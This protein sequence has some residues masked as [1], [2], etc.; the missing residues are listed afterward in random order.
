MSQHAYSASDVEYM[1]EV[2]QLTLDAPNEPEV[3]GRL[4]PHVVESTPPEGAPALVG[5]RTHPGASVVRPEL[6]V[7][8][9]AVRRAFLRCRPNGSA[10]VKYHD[11]RHVFLL[12]KP[13]ELTD[14]A[15]VNEW[16]HIRAS[17]WIKTY[18]ADGDGEV[19]WPDFEATIKERVA[20]KRLQ[21]K[22]IIFMTFDEPGSGPL[23]AKISIFVLLLIF[24]S[25]LAFVAETSPQ[26][27]IGGECNRCVE[28]EPDKSGKTYPMECSTNEE[29][30]EEYDSGWICGCKEP[31]PPQFFGYI[32]VSDRERHTKTGRKKARGRGDARA[33]ALSRQTPR[34]CARSL[35]GHT[36]VARFADGLHH[37]FHDR[38]PRAL[39]DRQRRAQR[40]H[41]DGLRPRRARRGGRARRRRRA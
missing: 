21:T 33:R 8:D 28:L 17:T 20:S 32:E 34:S 24:I 22:E 14:R 27:M 38:V 10:R 40:A 31:E 6:L 30:S 18:D 1:Q 16:L 41:R 36:R 3:P 35:S 19:S 26:L 37:H 25:V 2:E 29:C 11:I 12:C 9:A 39:L 13:V 4:A 7:D 5:T 15:D 23:A